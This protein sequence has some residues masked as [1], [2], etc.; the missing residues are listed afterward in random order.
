MPSAPPSGKAGSPLKRALRRGMHA[1]PPRLRYY[2]ELAVGSLAYT[3]AQWRMPAYRVRGRLLD[4]E[5]HGTLIHVGD[6]PQY[7]TWVDNVFAEADAPQ[8]IGEFPLLDVARRRGALA[9]ADLLLCP[10]NPL[11][12]LLFRPDS[13][14]IVPKYVEGVVHLDRP[15]E[16]LFRQSSAKRDLGVIKKKNF[17]YKILRDDSALDE[18]YRTML[19]PSMTTRH[20]SRVHITPLERLRQTFQRGHL[21]AAYLDEVWVG[22][23]LVVPGAGR[24][25]NAALIG[26]RDG[27]EQ[28][29]K[30]RV[31]SALMYETIV[32]AR[33]DG[34]AAVHM[35]SSAPFVNDGP[36][37]F[38]VKWG[39]RPSVPPL[40]IEDD[41]LQGLN[42][43]LAVGYRLASDAARAMLKNAPILV[44]S[45][46]GLRAVGW[47]SSLRQD[48][49]YLLEAGVTWTDLAAPIDVA[50]PQV[51]TQPGAPRS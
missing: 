45:G 13:W 46:Q 7:K 44:D 27:S 26:W 18:F 25:L 30:D 33:H 24:M 34:F 39:M 49:K 41:R 23:M 15:L 20:E 28:L 6:L 51:N 29:M 31:P 5:A 21:L 43:L 32:R 40:G 3:R 14:F 10:I 16:Q 42:A 22:A 36:L 4:S 11:S 48:F 1:L 19:V 47:Q 12:R 17:S 37:N 38:K 8:L 35:G 9:D 50:D 2:S